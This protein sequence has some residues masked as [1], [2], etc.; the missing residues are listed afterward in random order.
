MYL[1]IIKCDHG[2]GEQVTSHVFPSQALAASFIADVM[3]LGL[4]FEVLWEGA[5]QAQI[6]FHLHEA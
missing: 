2:A 5:V 3:R 6:R 1:L 4:D